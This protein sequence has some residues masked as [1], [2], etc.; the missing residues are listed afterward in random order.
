MSGGCAHAE[1]HLDVISSLAMNAMVHLVELIHCQALIVTGSQILEQTCR[2]SWDL[3][4]QVD[5]AKLLDGCSPVDLA[6]GG[7][8]RLM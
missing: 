3:V 2:V 1:Q 7:T 6:W 4:S 5:W 8:K